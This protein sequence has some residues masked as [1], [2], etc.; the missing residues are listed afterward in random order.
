MQPSPKIIPFTKP[1][2]VPRKPKNRTEDG[3][4]NPDFAPDGLPALK[5]KLRPRVSSTLRHI[6]SSIDGIEPSDIVD[7]LIEQAVV[8]MLDDYEVMLSTVGDALARGRER[9]AAKAQG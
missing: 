8:S 5:C 9:Q 4:L 2:T 1:A 6:C 7:V 3:K